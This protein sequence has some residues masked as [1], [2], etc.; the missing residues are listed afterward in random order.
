MSSAFLSR[1]RRLFVSLA[2][3]ATAV[4]G[5]GLLYG[6]RARPGASPVK[7]QY[8]SKGKVITP[9]FPRI[10]TRVEQLRDLRAQ[11]RFDLVIIGGGSTGAGIALDAVTRGLKVALV[12]RGDFSSGT[13]SKST[14]LVHGGVRY[15]EKAFCEM[16]WGQMKLVMEALRERRTFLQ[17]A[18]H[19]SNELAIMLPLYKWWQAPYFYA[20]TVAYDLL[21]GS[22]GLHRSSLM[23]PTTALDEFPHLNKR[24]LLG[25]LVYYDGQHNDARMNV[26][27]VTTAAAY[28]ATVANYVEVTGLEK[29]KDGKISGIRAR[30]SLG[31]SSEEEFVVEANGVINATGPFVDGIRKMDDPNCQDIVAPSLGAHI[32][33]PRHL[34]PKTMGLLDTGTADGRLLF[35]LPWEG[36]A[37]VG[38]TDTACSVAQDIP[39]VD[40][41]VDFI[42][43]EAQK[44]LS[45]DVQLKKEH[46]LSS[47]TGKFT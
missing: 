38:T 43:R 26:G 17:I 7:L 29:G 31:V 45:P 3:G 19:L 34:C 42:L 21:A 20:G 5:G 36:R 13:S 22:R 18:P 15:L 6:S 14:K 44:L 27:L 24:G 11:G 40:A 39:A 9:S 1:Y 32:I 12:E 47:W 28:G 16:S 10:P 33:L 23:G 37:L 8:D 2:A 35:V 41:D 46:V 30:D 4:V 25:A